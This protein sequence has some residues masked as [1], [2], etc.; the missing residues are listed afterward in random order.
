MVSLLRPEQLLKDIFVICSQGKTNH[1]WRIEQQRK[2]IGEVDS[3]WLQYVLPRPV[4]TQIRHWI[5]KG[6]KSHRSKIF[7][8]DWAVKKLCP[9][10]REGGKGKPL[11]PVRF[12]YHKWKL[13]YLIKSY[14]NA[15]TFT[16]LFFKAQRIW[17]TARILF[18]PRFSWGSPLPPEELLLVSLPD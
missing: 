4:P 15:E 5:T 3:S 11:T 18:F 7:T 2:K 1:L 10:C 13:A 16:V 9:Y 17:Q 8:K 14:G 6:P 12:P